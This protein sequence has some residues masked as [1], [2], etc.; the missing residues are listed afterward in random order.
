VR[1][2]IHRAAR[3]LVRRGL[4]HGLIE[5]NVTWLGVAAAAAVV[6][7]LT[8]EE[9]PRVVREELRIGE[10]ITVSHEPAP[11]RRRVRVR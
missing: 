6:H 7:L 5:G 3:G 11:S 1:K 9:S 10:T 8:R 4:R 2:A